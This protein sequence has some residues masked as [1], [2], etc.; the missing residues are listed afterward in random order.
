MPRCMVAVLA[1]LLAFVPVAVLAAPLRAGDH[2]QLTVFNHPELTFAQATIDGDGKLAMPLV[3][4]VFVAGLEPDAAAAKIGNSLKTYLREPVVSLSV[5]Q[6]N[7]T[8]SVVGGPSSTLPYVPGQT[9]SSIVSTVSSTPGLDL[10]HVILQRNGSTFG[11]YDGLDLLRRAD[12]GPALAPGDQVVFAQKP[13]SVNVLGLVHAPGLTHLDRG[14]SILDAVNAAGG[15]TND[16]ATGAV[17]VLRDGVHQHVALSSDVASQPAHDGDV[18][19]VPQAVHVAVSG[20]VGHPGDTPLTNGTTL[21]AAVYEAG[22]P[23]KYGD[24]SHTE[25]V[26]DGVRHVYD[27]TKVPGG[28]T[29]QNPHLS[30]GDI[31]NVPAGGHLNLSDIFGGAGVIHWFF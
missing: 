26:H 18:V 1:A 21:V 17:D 31:V 24:V 8:I 29:S 14:S 13:L 3:G 9:L 25:V 20:Q 11:T 19:T 30:E 16:A 6:Q 2:I 4:N 23:L 28:D 12:A 22:G 27:I 10:H 5:V 7:A 15:V